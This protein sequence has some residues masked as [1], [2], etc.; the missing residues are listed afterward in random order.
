MNETPMTAFV[1]LVDEDGNPSLVLDVPADFVAVRRQPSLRD[2]R[3][4]LLD[5]SADLAAQAAGQYAAAFGQA[6]EPSPGERVAEALSRR[7]DD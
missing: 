1:V 6:H 5:L 7:D 2:V 4:A 3:R